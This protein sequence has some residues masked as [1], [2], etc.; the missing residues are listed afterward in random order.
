MY[1]QVSQLVNKIKDLLQPLPDGSSGGS[2]VHHH[3]DLGED[4]GTAHWT[5]ST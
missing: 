5:C 3:S 1:I 4:R 2:V